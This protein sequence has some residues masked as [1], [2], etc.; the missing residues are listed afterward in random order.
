MRKYLIVGGLIIVCLFAVLFVYAGLDKPFKVYSLDNIS[1]EQSSLNSQITEVKSLQNETLKNK[2]LEIDKSLKVYNEAKEKYNDLMVTAT[3]NNKNDV[4]LG[5]YY[6]IEYLWTKLGVIATKYGVDMSLQISRSSFVNNQS[7]DYVFCDFNF[8][9]TGTYINV[10]DF[11]YELEDN[12]KLA[13][14]TK[15]FKM[16]SSAKKDDTSYVTATFAVKNIP[17]SAD[18]LSNIDDKT[19]SENSNQTTTD[20]QASNNNTQNDSTNSTTNKVNNNIKN[21]PSNT[22]SSNTTNSTNNSTTNT[23]SS[24]NTTNTAN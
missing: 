9:I 20:G 11:L 15:D 8:T 24:N 23:S 7:Q 3:E 2:K 18:G 16:V 14:V 22:N 21:G 17:L 5:D 12:N 19:N 6:D 4:V 10:T 1:K 13:F